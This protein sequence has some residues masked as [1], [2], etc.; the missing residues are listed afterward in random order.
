MVSSHV[1]FVISP[2]DEKLLKQL[3][4]KTGLNTKNKHPSSEQDQNFFLMNQ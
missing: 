4:T 1:V 3:V 2:E